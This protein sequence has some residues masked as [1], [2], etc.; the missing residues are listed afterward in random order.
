M[1]TELYHYGVKGQRWGVRRY[2]NKDG[3]LTSAGR[4]RISKEYKKLSVKAAQ[5]QAAGYTQQYVNAHNKAADY[6]NNGEIDR[7]N[8]KY[9]K[10]YGDDYGGRADYEDEMMKA[11][12][13]RLA[14]NFNKATYDFYNNN[15]Y[16][17][18]AQELVE[19]YNMTEW[20]SLAKENT[21]AINDVRLAVEKAAK[22]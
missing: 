7:I 15:V 4:K 3:S 21:A 16:S 2:Q 9:Q 20:D 12:S 17:K 5:E 18:K 19:R 14:E 13:D 11:F 1:N 6:M 8:A 22:H 10:K